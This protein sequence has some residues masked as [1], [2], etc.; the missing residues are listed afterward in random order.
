MKKKA[1]KKES[2]IVVARISVD[3]YNFMK[4]DAAENYRTIS[5]Q[6]RY[7]IDEWLKCRSI[8]HDIGG[9]L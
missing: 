6:I 2:K 1:I 3:T 7:I 5:G 4:C 8:K 9:N